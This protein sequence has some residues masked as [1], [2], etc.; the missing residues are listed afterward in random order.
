MNLTVLLLSRYGTLGASSRVR[1]YQYL[2]YLKTEG[3]DVTVAPLLED[4]YLEDLYAGRRMRMGAIARAYFQRLRYLLKSHRF[5]LLWVEYELLPWLPAWAEVALS[6]WRIPYVV[7][8]DDATFHRY[9]LHPNRLVKFFLGK[10]I[11]LVMR[12]ADLVIVGNDYLAERALQV[13]AKKVEYLPTVV[14]T[15]R[16]N[17]MPQTDNSIFTIG[18][19]GSPSTCQYLHDLWPGLTEI[20]RGGSARLILVGSGEVKFTGVPLDIRSWSEKTEVEDIKTFDVGIM[21]LRDGFWERGKC[22][23]KLIQY[24]ATYRPVVASPVGV[25]KKIVEQGVNGFL[26]TTT[27]DWVKSLSILREDRSLRE[28]MGKSGRSKVESQYCLR[29][30]APRL[31]ALLRDTVKGLY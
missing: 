26:A 21:P 18:W 30:T 24:M 13:G 4:Q 17:A 16:Y 29:V 9:E 27:Q 10:K 11:D 31:A 15:N 8:Y 20:C 5:D 1:S 6:A 23:Y 3:I 19:I 7:D 25:N 28:R 22:G 2:P 14:D 12:R